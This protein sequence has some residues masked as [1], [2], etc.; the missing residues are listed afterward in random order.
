[1]T[2][3]TRVKAPTTKLQIPKK[4]QI[5]ITKHRR[6]RAVWCLGFWNWDFFGAWSLE[7]GVSPDRGSDRQSQI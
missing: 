2:K 3:E 7:I 5:Q 6:E 4:L 1:M